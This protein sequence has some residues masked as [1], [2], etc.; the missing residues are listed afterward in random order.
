MNVSFSSTAYQRFSFLLLKVPNFMWGFVVK[1]RNLKN[2]PCLKTL[3]FKVNLKSKTGTI[4]LLLISENWSQTEGNSLEKLNYTTEC[5]V[6]RA[7]YVSPRGTSTTQVYLQF[8]IS[9]WVILSIL[10]TKHT[11]KSIFRMNLYISQANHTINYVPQSFQ[12]SLHF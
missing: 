4:Y 8:R 6:P 12:Q 5:T 2:D 11:V 1:Y 7:H 10:P 3:K 9:N